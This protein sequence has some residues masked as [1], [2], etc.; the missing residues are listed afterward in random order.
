MARAGAG[1]MGFQMTS[2]L[3]RQPRV[4]AA[5]DPPPA[6]ASPV[7]PELAELEVY[8]RTQRLLGWI[9]PEG[10]RTSDW[11]NRGHEMEFLAPVE[12]PLDALRPQL[13]EA[14][15]DPRRV[16]IAATDV[17]FAV[18]PSLPQGRHLRLHRRVILIHFEMDDYDLHGRIHVR[19]GAEVGDYLLRSSRVF[20]PITDAELTR[21]TEPTF[22]RSLPVVIVNSRHVSR[23]H[24]V[25]GSSATIAG[26]PERAAPATMLAAPI[27]DLASE[28]ADLDAIEPVPGPIHSA[29][30]ELAALHRD[31]LISEREFKAKRAEILKRL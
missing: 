22:A 16:R 14:T 4:P 21:T 28:G 3:W 5:P 11:M 29:L 7:W 8:T 23:L 9:A 13:A 20:V 24:L 2:L 25:E 15:A 30:S 18:P 19:P 17:V 27:L 6:P 10:E 12:V 26:Q 31:G 1:R